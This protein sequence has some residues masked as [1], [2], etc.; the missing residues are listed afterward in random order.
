M[1]Q[2]AKWSHTE[3]HEN[4]SVISVFIKG[5][6]QKK[7]WCLYESNTQLI[8]KNQNCFVVNLHLYFNCIMHARGRSSCWICKNIAMGHIFKLSANLCYLPAH[9]KQRWEL[10]SLCHQRTQV[11][12]PTS[13]GTP[14]N[15]PASLYLRRSS[16][17]FSVPD[18]NVMSKSFLKYF[19]FLW[20]VSSK[21]FPHR[22]LDF[23]LRNFHSKAFI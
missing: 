9:F 3:S 23:P 12:Q 11:G 10:P 5:E 19:C 8:A 18:F 7:M 16:F 20:K 15:H 1:E 17:H 22:N 21:L 2:L 14:T 4:L 6:M 13:P